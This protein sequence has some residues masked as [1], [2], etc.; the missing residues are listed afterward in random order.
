M[1]KLMP[2]VSE[3]AV[4]ALPGAAAQSHL[5]LGA[6]PLA[7]FDA[8]SVSVILNTDRQEAT[9]RCGTL[10]TAGLLTEHPHGYTFTDSQA[11][12]ALARIDE[13]CGRLIDPA[14]GFDRLADHFL[15]AAN[16][17]EQRIT[18]SHATV[19]RTY[20]TPAP[21][22]APYADDEAAALRW[23]TWQLPNYMALI[24]HANLHQ[25]STLVW[26]LADALWPL[27][28]RRRHPAERHEAHLLALAAARADDNDTATGRALTT[29]AATAAGAGRPREAQT[30]HYQAIELYTRIQDPIGLA[31]ARNG[32]AKILRDAGAF[33][34]AKALFRQAL[35][36]RAQHNYLRGVALSLQGLGTIAL[37]EGD[38]SAARQYLDEAYSILIDENDFYDAALTR[39]LCARATAVCQGHRQ[40]M[41]ELDQA[42]AAF[43]HAPSPYAEALILETT[44]TI[45]HSFGELPAARTC[46]ASA[47]HLLTDL[48]PVARNRVNTRLDHLDIP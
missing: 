33:T 42:R 3:T 22:P 26:Q 32:L 5:L 41:A 36:S 10:I 1:E 45:H 39:A 18:P 2:L 25:L 30:C 20:R 40:A 12:H 21:T 16:T 44:G 37:A 8:Q 7:W 9:A 27:W 28:L 19:P 31:Q 6:C 4:A 34:A 38:A 24:R 47:A 11:A 35:E 14:A 48:D 43:A 17:A 29:L 23:L 13:D 15:L 46:Y